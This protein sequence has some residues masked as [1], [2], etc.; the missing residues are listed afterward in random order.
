MGS[1]HPRLVLTFY[2]VLV[3]DSPRVS[4]AITARSD[5]AWPLQSMGFIALHAQRTLPGRA[6]APLAAFQTTPTT[7]RC[8][9]RRLGCGPGTLVRR[10]ACLRGWAGRRGIVGRGGARTLGR[11][12][13]HAHGPRRGL[14]LQHQPA[15]ERSATDR[16]L[17]GQGAGGRVAEINPECRVHVREEWFTLDEGAVLADELSTAT[18]ARQQAARGAPLASPCR[19]DRRACG[20]VRDHGGVHPA[21]RA[22]GRR[23]RLG[24]RSD[25]SA[26]RVS[27]LTRTSRD[28]LL[29]SSPHP[30]PSP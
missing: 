22:H 11:G 19:R 2:L 6:P 23:G 18:A 12:L 13:A 21:G 17:Q 10:L 8:A 29:S 26:V 3:C 16:S 15:D 1:Q 24:R 7:T 14:H 20:E 30:S 25:P 9:S 27:D 4:A 28:P 5:C